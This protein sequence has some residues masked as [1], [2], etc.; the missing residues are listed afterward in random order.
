LALHCVAALQELN[1]KARAKATQAQSHTLTYLADDALPYAR[2]V[3]VEAN[4]VAADPATG[5]VTLVSDA[6][7]R[8]APP[9]EASNAKMLKLRVANVPPTDP[10]MVPPG[11]FGMARK[12][13]L[14]CKARGGMADVEI[15]LL[16]LNASLAQL[17]DPA[18]WGLLLTPWQGQRAVELIQ[19]DEALRN[20]PLPSPPFTFYRGQGIDMNDF[21]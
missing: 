7:R 12:L 5:R 19:K 6:I 20:V 11:N 13:L 21:L 17:V 15:V 18:D 16:P 1:H 3:L 8:L 4:V 9:P 10:V 2:V 14:K